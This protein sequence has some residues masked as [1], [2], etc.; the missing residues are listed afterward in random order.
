MIENHSSTL[1]NAI[2]I[3]YGRYKHLDGSLAHEKQRFASS[4]VQ[5]VFLMVLFMWTKEYKTANKTLSK[6]L[7]VVSRIMSMLNNS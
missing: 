7:L 2:F 4:A 5:L 6:L 1:A 3:F